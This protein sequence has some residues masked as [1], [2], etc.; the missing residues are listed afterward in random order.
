M[1]I[2]IYISDEVQYVFVDGVQY[3]AGPKYWQ[4]ANFRLGTEIEFDN[5]VQSFEWLRRLSNETTIENYALYIIHTLQGE[6]IKILANKDRLFLVKNL[7]EHL[8]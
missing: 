8:A 4:G 7:P 1:Y 6:H 5:L 3:F 2:R